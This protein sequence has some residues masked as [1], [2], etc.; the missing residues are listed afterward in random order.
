MGELTT[1][2]DILTHMGKLT[3]EQ[4]IL[5]MEH[6]ERVMREQLEGTLEKYSTITLEQWLLIELRDVLVLEK[7][8]SVK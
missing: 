6:G 7:F 4:R 5:T 1:E 2:Q 3:T 8:L